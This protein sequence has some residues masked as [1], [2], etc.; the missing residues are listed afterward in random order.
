MKPL[1]PEPSRSTLV[2]GRTALISAVLGLP[3]VV[4]VKPAVGILVVLLFLFAVAVLL[5]DERRP[6]PLRELF[7]TRPDHSGLCTFVRHPD[8]RDADPWVLRSVFEAMVDVTTIPAEEFAVLPSDR[9]ADDLGIAD[10][11]V[12]DIDRIVERAERVAPGA[13]DPRW[14]QVLTVGDFV[15]L[16]DSF[17]R[18]VGAS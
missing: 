13:R 10:D 17:P 11:L 18:A 2:L 12:W 5:I 15:H 16:L 1:H 9:F 3:V 8:V 6:D 4:W 7:A 14:E